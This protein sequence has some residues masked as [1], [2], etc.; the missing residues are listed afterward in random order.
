MV[1]MEIKM[2][3]LKCLLLLAALFCGTLSF[4]DTQAEIKNCI[5]NSIKAALSMNWNEFK[6][7]CSED[8]VKISQD[9][10]VFDNKVLEQTILYFEGMKNPDLT[11]SE[12][13]KL[14]SMMKGEPLSES[15]LAIYRKFDS[16]ERGKQLVRQAQKQTLEAFNDMCQMVNEVMEK[17]QYGPLFIEDNLAVQFYKLDY[18][19][20]TKGAIILRKEKGKWKLFREFSIVDTGNEPHIPSAAEVEKFIHYY[21][22]IAYEFTDFKKIAEFYSQEWIGVRS[23]KQNLSYRKLVKKIKLYDMLENGTPTAVQ[24]GT[25]SIES[26]GAKVTPIMLN[27]FAEMDRN[28]QTE[29][30]ITQ[31]RKAIIKYREDIKKH[32]KYSIKKIF[33]FEDCALVLSDCVMP[34]SGKHDKISLIKK[35][36]GKYLF[37]RD[38]IRKIGKN[39]PVTKCPNCGE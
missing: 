9:Q 27:Y 28:G 18:F 31:Y 29:K 17:T 11:Y 34:N 16:T 30:W 36:Q 19:V 12:L 7:F 32:Y 33:I 15:R 38:V 5:N 4:A 23:G 26:S 13:A 21:Q 14:T 3:F 39:P 6:K 20:K 2:V 10:K 1:T 35:Y 37:C 24:A 22:K 25:L 8:Y